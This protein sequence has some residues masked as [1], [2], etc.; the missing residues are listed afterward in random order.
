M[1]HNKFI[2]AVT[3]LA[4][5]LGVCGSVMPFSPTA[6]AAGNTVRLDPS[7]A[8]PFNDGKFEGWG[9]SMGWWGNRIGHSDKM[10]QQAAE[11]LYSEEGLGL[12]IVRYNVGGGDNPTHNHINRSDSKLP[13]FAVPQYEGGTYQAEEGVNKDVTNLKKDAN[14]D[15]IYD[16]DWDADHDQINVLK[17]I[18]EQNP[19]VHIEGY[20]NSPP[21]LKTSIRQIMTCLRIFLLRLRNTWKKSGCR[22]TAIRR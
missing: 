10:A 15:V 7:E 14:G 17:R 11:D 21:W 19:D 4:L 18:K 5:T 22:L 6:Y 1:R 13:C 20:T 3:T 9:T 2:C 16:W 12:D 8:S